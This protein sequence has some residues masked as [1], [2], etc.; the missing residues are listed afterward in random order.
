ML[1]D[2]SEMLTVI[3][4]VAFKNFLNLISNIYLSVLVYC[5]SS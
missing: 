5:I 2:E 4:A 3:V 1:I